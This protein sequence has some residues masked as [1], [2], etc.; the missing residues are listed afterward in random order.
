MRI[1]FFG[2]VCLDG[3]DCNRFV[4][5]PGIVALAAAAEHNVANLESP[6]TDATQGMPYRVRLMKA[7]PRPNH[8]LDLFDIFTL[9]NNHIM[10][11][12]EPGLIDTLEFL[13]Q[14]NKRS[15]GAG[16]NR[17]QSFVPLQLIGEEVRLAFVGFTRWRTA[18]KISAGTTPDQLRRLVRLVADLSRDGYF[19]VV[20]PHWNYEYVD[21]PA[22]ANRRIA[23]KIIDAG[24]DLIVG[25]H[26]HIP[27]GYER[28]AGKWIFHSL[29]NFV[30]DPGQLSRAEKN[31]PRIRETIILQIDVQRDRS[32]HCE[33]I[34]V[35]TN[36]DGVSLV[37]ADER[38]AMLDRLAALSA[39]FEDDRLASRAF[40]K[41]ATREVDRVG[42]QMNRMV[43]QKGLMYILSRLH[44]IQHQDIK[45]KLHG[46]FSR[47]S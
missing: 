9:A 12:L 35:R 10:D 32:C 2:D 37:T 18:T 8:I 38:A 24:A 17:E 47:Q 15:F 29:G 14:E 45:I 1:N 33:V 3:I 7:P 30:F 5:D 46:M 13:Q 28:Y 16:L 19:V 44:R 42:A 26:P 22:P 23:K 34:P 20:Y 25:S 31:D 36:A 27:Q 11:Y 40:Y 21:Y 39:V 43:K 4:V 6:L 41:Q